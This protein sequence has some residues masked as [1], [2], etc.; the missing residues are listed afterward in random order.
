MK[1]VHIINSLESGGA[2]KLLLDTLPF[3][4]KKDCCGS[5]CAKWIW[6]SVFWALRSLGCCSIHSL[7]LG[8]AY[9]PLYVFKMPF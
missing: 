2:E 9:N 7:G 3:I 6:L 4:I 1:I 5:H 8:S